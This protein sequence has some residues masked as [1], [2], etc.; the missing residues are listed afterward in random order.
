MNYGYSKKVDLQYRDAI[1]RTKEALANAGFG[2]LTEID[3]Q[4]TLKEKLDIDEEPYLILGAC[5]PKLAHQAIKA[6]TEIGLLLPCNV[7]VYEREG[8]VTVSAILPASAMSIV[9]NPKLTSVAS[10]VES[11]LKQVIDT[12]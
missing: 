3:V 2:V 8:E 10:E 4:A 1:T 12:I 6:E 5:N 7:I 11:Q 9:D